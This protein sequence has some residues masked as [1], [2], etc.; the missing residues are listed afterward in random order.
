MKLLTV[1]AH[2]T[3]TPLGKV[4]ALLIGKI[5]GRLV[6]WGSVLELHARLKTARPKKR[7]THV[8]LVPGDSERVV[9]GRGGSVPEQVFC[10]G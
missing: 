4:L 7:P 6:D 1:K 5:C 2:R 9:R 8:P 3:R 10:R